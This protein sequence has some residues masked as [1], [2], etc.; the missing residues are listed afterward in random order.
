MVPTER[1]VVVT[2]GGAERVAMAPPKFA[3]LPT[4]SQLTG[5]AQA[6]PRREATPDGARPLVHPVPPSVVVR[7]LA[8]PTAVHVDV[9]MQLIDCKAVAP[10]GVPRSSHMEPP[11]VVPTTSDPVAKQVVSLAHETPLRTVAAA[12]GVC[13]TQVDPPFPVARIT[14]PGPTDDTPTAVQCRASAQE[15]PVKLVTVPGNASGAQDSPALS[16]AMMLGAE[17]PKSLT[18]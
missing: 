10:P 6:T 18:A 14:P 3:S 16:V 1:L 7:M 4:A 12:G 8:P 17:L 13:G 5:L 11:S 15:M 9:L 2:L